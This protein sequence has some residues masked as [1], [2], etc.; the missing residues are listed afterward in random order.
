MHKIF[1]FS[2]QFLF[3]FDTRQA[4]KINLLFVRALSGNQSGSPVPLLGNWPCF[5]HADFIRSKGEGK[6]PSGS[7]E[8]ATATVETGCRRLL[9]IFFCFRFFTS[10]AVLDVVNLYNYFCLT[11]FNLCPRSATSMGA[12]QEFSGLHKPRTALTSLDLA[13]KAAFGDAKPWRILQHHFAPIKVKQICS[14]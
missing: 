11:K 5:G 4:R 9:R 10:V 3:G 6:E 8:T 1:V 13:A 12:C 7:L 14:F 2:T